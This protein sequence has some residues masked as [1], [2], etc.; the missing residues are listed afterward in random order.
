MSQSLLTSSVAP[1][2]LMV[3]LVKLH[4]DRAKAHKIGYCSNY[5]TAVTESLWLK[6]IVNPP[7]RPARDI[8]DICPRC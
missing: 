5:H 8:I 1:C 3:I 7:V 6:Q 2:L 4:V